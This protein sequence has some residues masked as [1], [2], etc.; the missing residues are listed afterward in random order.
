M[1]TG[2]L[3]PISAQSPNG[4]NLGRNDLPKQKC[5]GLS[6]V[7]SVNISHTM[8]RLLC[9]I[10]TKFYLF[11]AVIIRFSLQLQQLGVGILLS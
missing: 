11:M 3:L 7:N 8:S 9:N 6:G 10:L 5:S 4:L 2:S 1:Q